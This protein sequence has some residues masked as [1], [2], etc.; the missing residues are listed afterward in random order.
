[1]VRPT[2]ALVVG[3]LALLAAAPRARADPA[4]L[5]V[6][7]ESDT[8]C[9]SA[10]EVRSAL[11]TCFGAS[12]VALGVP[13]PGELGLTLTAQG[14]VLQLELRD[15]TDLTAEA[16]R[17]PTRRRLP[18]AQGT[19]TDVAQTI[20]LLVDA[21]L[22]DLP[23]HGVGFLS[24]AALAVPLVLPP[25]IPEPPPPPNPPAK[26]VP[27][28]RDYQ[29]PYWLGP[30]TVRLS[31]GVGFPD[32]AATASSSGTLAAE[33]G[34]FERYGGG[35]FFSVQGD[36]AATDYNSGIAGTQVSAHRQTFGFT[37][38]YSLVNQD[39][40]GLRFYAGLLL[41]RIGAQSTGY[42]TDGNFTIVNPAGMLAVQWQ[43]NLTHT[44]ALFAQGAFAFAP[45]TQLQVIEAPNQA[46]GTA[47]NVLTIQPVWL[48]LS[49]GI[50]VR[51]F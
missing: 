3:I 6:L 33:V 8:G 25:P 26:P 18:L 34:I 12:R 10:E 42:S 37:G 43:Q 20:A 21:W 29:L 14:E 15:L 38:R 17:P 40:N 32:D 41:Q 13:G 48:D 24:E 27:P 11:A 50:A 46:S 47:T 1:M 4:L 51:L 39:Q 22:R 31:G 28:S 7:S 30:L 44:L 16:P 49:V 23:W 36:L 45:Q 2:V 19:C 35:V 9:P 5:R